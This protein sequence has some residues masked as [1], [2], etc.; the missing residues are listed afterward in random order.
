MLVCLQ[1]FL[2]LGK[3]DFRKERFS[4]LEVAVRARV[5][6]RAVGEKEPHS[7]RALSGEENRVSVNLAVLTLGL[8]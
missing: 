7:K 6:L 1:N 8:C 5:V 4:V 3:P 2:R